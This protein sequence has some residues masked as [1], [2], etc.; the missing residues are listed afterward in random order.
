MPDDLVTPAVAG[1]VV[2]IALLLAVTTAV[3][4]RRVLRALPEPPPDHLGDAP[5][6]RYASLP[7]R[8][9]RLGVGV[10]VGLAVGL[11]GLAVSPDGWPIWLGIC[12]VGVLLAWIDARTTWLPFVLTTTLWALTA[13]GYV[14]VTVMGALA[15][16]G[17]LE[18]V[19]PLL[20]AAAAG[21]VFW[22]VH[23]IGR[24]ALGFGDVRLVPPL[25]AA[26][27][28]VSLDVALIGLLLGT[29]AAAAYAVVRLLL[30]RRG[31]FAYGPWLVAGCLAGVLLAG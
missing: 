5:A 4:C 23:R 12:T 21:T 10:T 26:A 16:R 20:A 14:V 13:A 30:R 31:E 1:P 11:V 17:A 9:F 8:G 15:G 19:T 2:V 6:P 25:V 29:G 22:I 24:G 7:T 27:A 18:L 3:A 28:S